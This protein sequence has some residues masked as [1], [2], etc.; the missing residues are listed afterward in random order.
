MFQII[1]KF[2]FLWI[3]ISMLLFAILCLA[4]MEIVLGYMLEE[5]DSQHI[6]RWMICIVTSM[7]MVCLYWINLLFYS[8]IYD[9]VLDKENYKLPEVRHVIDELIKFCYFLLFIAIGCYI[10]YVRMPI[11]NHIAGLV[12]IFSLFVGLGSWLMLFSKARHHIPYKKEQLINTIAFIFFIG[13]SLLIE[14]LHLSIIELRPGF[15]GIF[16]VILM[17]IVL[18]KQVNEGKF[19]E[20]DTSYR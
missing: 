1:K 13:S 5:K 12:L 4:T 14:K 11:V 7:A 2:K 16:A 17:T 20:I 3:S 15:P 8:R 9:F 18:Y 10:Y 6:V 19:F